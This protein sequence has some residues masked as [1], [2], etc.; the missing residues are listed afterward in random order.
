M[1]FGVIRSWRQADPNLV[2]VPCFQVILRQ[3][4]ANLAGS[5]PN[6]GILVGVVMGIAP[7]N[8]DSERTLLQRFNVVLS[9][10]LD[11]VPQKS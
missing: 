1:D 5:T 7:K 4:L 2:P 9:G 10:V 11:D 6:H 3:S 8:L